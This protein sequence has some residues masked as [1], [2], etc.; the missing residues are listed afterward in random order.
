MALAAEAARK[1]AKC[2]QDHREEARSVET[3]PTE[4]E[5]KSAAVNRVTKN[6]S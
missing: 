1:D 3:Q 6:A 4:M 2:L 5:E